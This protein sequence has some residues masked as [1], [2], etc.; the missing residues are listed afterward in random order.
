MV[1]KLNLPEKD[2]CESYL[3]GMTTIELAKEYNCAHGTILN[4]LHKNNIKIKSRS[5]A[6]TG[7]TTGKNHPLYIDLPINQII[8]EY[9]NGIST[10]KLGEKYGCNHA[11]IG[12]KLKENGID[13]TNRIDIP[14][15]HI[16]DEYKNGTSTIEL[17]KKYRCNRTTINKKLKENNIDVTNHI[18]LPIDQIIE[19]YKIGLS[20][21]KLAE[22]YGCSSTTI[23][24]KLR[25]N[26][27]KIRSISEATTGS[28][29]GDN[30]PCYIDLPIEEICKKYLGGISTPKLAKDYKCSV[31]TI[32]IRLREN[33]IT[34]RSNS[35]SHVG[36]K[37]GKDN[38][39]WKGGISQ[40]KYCY[41]FNL[42]LKEA[43]RLYFN[44]NCFMDNEP[45]ENGRSLSVHHVGYDKRCGCD[46][47]Q[48]C[49]FI[50]VKLKWNIKF[51]GSKEHN[52]WYWYSFL[53]N[54][55]FIEHPNYFVYHIP[56]WGMNEL[57]YNYDYVF[58][59]FRR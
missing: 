54:K 17:S 31:G 12:R 44:N 33:G 58:E 47:T 32:K 35:E 24:V 38:P 39:N 5:E 26:E 41:L 9:R 22:K 28:R 56:V 43:I 25:E 16:I 20:T 57:E 29:L 40:Q 10:I 14:I 6:R 13:V 53:M 52:R 1:K 46:A 11:T 3:N 36:L 7:R 50:P 27:I 8:D 48:F 34:I 21:V 49:I 37:T 4:R 23:A 55:I 18:D 19:D 42:T 30:S 2:I 59:K 45:E 51:N 15:E